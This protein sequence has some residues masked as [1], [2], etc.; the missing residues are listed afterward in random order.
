MFWSAVWAIPGPQALC[1]SF[2]SAFVLVPRSPSDFWPDG[3]SD[4]SARGTGEFVVD[5]FMAG[6]FLIPAQAPPAQPLLNRESQFVPLA[7]TDLQFSCRIGHATHNN[8]HFGK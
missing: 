4:L 2:S 5:M 3:Q 6:P 1:G 7:G 8:E